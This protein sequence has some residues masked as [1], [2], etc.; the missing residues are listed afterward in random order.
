MRERYLALYGRA[1]GYDAGAADRWT[2]VE[3]IPTCTRAFAAMIAR[4]RR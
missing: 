4:I 3:Q 1:G 2:S